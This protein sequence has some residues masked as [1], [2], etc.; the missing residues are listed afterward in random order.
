MSSDELLIIQAI[1]MR[2]PI[3]YQYNR[4]EKVVGKRSGNPH[5]IFRGKTKEGIEKVWVHIVQTGGAS[6]TLTEFPAWRMFIS[7]FVSDVE[8]LVNDP[9]F[10]IHDGYNPDSDM[11]TE[12]IEQI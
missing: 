11:Y 2:K 1:K 12:I 6:D 7:E 5:A 8:I 3:G 10:P 9:Q 4:A